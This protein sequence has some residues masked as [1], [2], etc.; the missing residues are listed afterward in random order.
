MPITTPKH[1]LPKYNNDSKHFLHVFEGLF[2]PAIK[3]L[4]YEP[5]PP[6]TIGSH[7]IQADIIKKIEDADLV[8]CDMAALNPNVFFELGIRT[9]L[10]KPVSLVK[11][12]VTKDIPFDTSIINFHTYLS[13]PTWQLE[14]EIEKLSKHIEDCIQS[15]N[16]HNTMWQKFGISMAVASVPENSLEAKIDL[17]FEKV[18]SLIDNDSRIKPIRDDD[19][20]PGDIGEM[21]YSLANSLGIKIE[22]IISDGSARGV[23]LFLAPTSDKRAT[24]LKQYL[25]NMGIT[26]TM[27]IAKEIK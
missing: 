15:S 16:G 8:L 26:V 27:S 2:E 4:D 22:Q 12:D 9:A 20:A 6:K 19:E 17:L 13:Q 3:K 5:I 23:M 24:Q 14:S 21:I 11:D 7:I 10:N 1:L 25:N 18:N